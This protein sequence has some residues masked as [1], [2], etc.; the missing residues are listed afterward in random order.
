MQPFAQF[1][2][3][4]LAK[5]RFVLTDVDDT[6]TEGAR[7]S[8]ATYDS[9]ERL[10]NAGLRVIPVTA[11]PAGW[12]DLICRMWPVAAIVG[13][14]G[15]LCFRHDPAAGETE[16]HFWTAAPDRRRDRER[17]AELGSSI[18]AL[19]PGSALAADQA[20]RQATLGVS[21]RGDAAVGADRRR[22]ERSRRAHG[23]QLAVGA[24]LVRRFRQAGD[25][26]QDDEGVVR[27]RCRA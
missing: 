9:L 12:C 20:Y 3:A 10:T 7:L 5:V 25:D 4:R 24:R 1:P 6:L 16:R 21:Q 23:R 14:N 26:S 15:G 18:E 27:D 8:A 17:L 11:A 2:R 19:V 13:E 22:T